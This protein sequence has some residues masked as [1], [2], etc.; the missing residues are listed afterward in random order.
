MIER[1]TFLG[2]F[3]KWFIRVF[4]SL[5]ALLPIYA[6]FI[7]ALTPSSHV[8]NLQLYPHYLEFS[9]F[10][11]GFTI[12]SNGI[13]NSFLY[14]S[15]S[16]I[17]TLFISIPA[18]Y[19]LARYNF[20]GKRVIL[21]TLLFTQMIAGIVLLPSLYVLFHQM[22]ISNSTLGV[23]LVMTG[24]NLALVIWILYGYFQTLPA[25]IE[26]A[27]MMDGCNYL[28]L[29]IK[30]IL[31][32]SGP[33]IAV[34]AIFVFINT[35]NEFVIPLFLFTSQ[36]KYPLTLSLYSMLTD[37]TMRWELI[38]AGS[39]IAIIPPILIFTFFQKYIIQ[40]LTSGSVKS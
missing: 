34:G 31:P 2:T 12:I 5:F 17:L 29:L 10:E 22:N 33:G 11:H 30:I 19:V 32:L 39:L 24:V 18:S 3:T 15:V 25:E 16:T 37:T 1:E 4:L 40:G 27:A 9:N 28:Q 38:A 20:R 8:M 23:I 36:T 13:K 21:F 26:E 7:I 6:A 35:Y 14:S